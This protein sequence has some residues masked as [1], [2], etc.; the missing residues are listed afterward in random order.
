[1]AG[2]DFHTNP[3]ADKLLQDGRDLL[4]RHQFDKATS[5]FGELRKKF[6]A[7]KYE[8]EDAE[9]S[10]H[11]TTYGREADRGIADVKHG[12]E[13]AAC[14]RLEGN[15]DFPK[16]H[17]ELFEKIRQGIE[18]HDRKA[19]LALTS[20]DFSAGVYSV[21]V[22]EGPDW[23]VFE[24]KQAGVRKVLQRGPALDWS[25]AVWPPVVTDYMLVWVNLKPKGKK[26]AGFTIRKGTKGWSWTE[27]GLK[28]DSK[29]DL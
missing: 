13:L 2:Y 23:W 16:T 9:D 29:N 21:N 4:E 7:V 8:Y 15:Q 27:Y 20:C 5:V 18:A 25:A 17:T 28:D 24:N 12:K 11:T 26:L 19:L 3:D 1:M 6:G 22:D 10:I 14:N